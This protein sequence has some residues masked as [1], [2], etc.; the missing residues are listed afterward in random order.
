MGIP[1]Y[2]YTLTKSYNNIISDKLLINPD[3]YCLDFNGVIHPICAKLIQETT[4]ENIIIEKLY[5]KVLD[6]IQNLKPKNC[7]ICIDG[8]V[9]M[10]KIIQ[11]RRRRYL[12][13]YKNK[14]DQLTAKWDT[15]AITPGTDFMNN[16]NIY[17]KKQIR[18][19]TSET[20]IIFSGSDEYGEG[21]HKIFTK[22][23]AFNNT[24]YNIVINGLDADLI[25]LSLLSHIKNITLMREAE[26]STYLNINNLRA[27]IISEL[28]NK[29]NISKIDD[30][31]SNEAK[32]LI[33]T[34]CV[35]CSLLGNDFIPHLLNLNLKQDGLDKLLTITGNS[36]Q[37]NGLLVHDNKIN[38]IALSDIFQNIAKTE[39][40][41]LYKDIEK[42][43]KFFVSK[44]NIPSEFY[45]LKYKDPIAT[46]IYANI[47]NWRKI[48]YKK[49]FHT[50]IT[51]DSSVI[52]STCY[53]YIYGIYWTYAYYKKFDYDNGW[54]YPYTYPPSI[55][56][57]ANYTLG[58]PEPIIKYND[59]KIN[60][61]IQLIIVLP[62]Y[63]I[64][65]LKSKYQ[66]F[67]TD[68]TLGLYHLYPE[69]YKIHTF[70]KTHLWECIPDLP[71]ININTIKKYIH[72]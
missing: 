35:M 46:E 54:Y 40:I 12:N 1:Y 65:L 7:I 52:P 51:I 2:F 36:Y 61:D 44:T 59:I 42:Y 13:I 71:T 47:A 3:I 6:D 28:C 24:N 69:T 37:I 66:K 72:T 18:Y 14:I 62:K 49:F 67:M 32:D 64:N 26:S 60:S 38:Y 68:K 22:L 53:Q 48:Y 50:N 45:G 31:Y 58:N 9:P 30:I 16:I 39:D 23:L 41:D 55:K 56:D 70:L 8:V 5:E 15:N 4:D 11:Q 57:I 25:I 29:W 27:A 34:Y 20:N 17:F 33:E 63:S 21:E 19:T 10:A 43:I